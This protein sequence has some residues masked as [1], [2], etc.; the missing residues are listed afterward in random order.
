MIFMD[1]FRGFSTNQESFEKMLK[2]SINILKEV[3]LEVGYDKCTVMKVKRGKVVEMSGI[4]ISLENVIE[5]V[6]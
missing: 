3:G 1:D 6:N 4:N 5:E 2:T